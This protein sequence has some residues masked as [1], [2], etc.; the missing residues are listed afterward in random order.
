MECFVDECCYPFSVRRPHSHCHCLDLGGGDGGAEGSLR[1][2]AL[3]GCLNSGWNTLVGKL[4]AV[5][6]R[7]LL[8]EE[9]R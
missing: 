7:F 5:V 3:L 8:T 9:A 6:S 2:F 4:Q 1:P